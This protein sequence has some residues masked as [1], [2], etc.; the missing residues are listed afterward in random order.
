MDI[1]IVGAGLIGTRRAEDAMALGHRIL[2]VADTDRDRAQQLADLTKARPTV[3]WHEAVDDQATQVVFACSTN[4]VNAEVAIAALSRE[5]HV[6]IEQ[7]MGRNA[8]EASR[9]LS[10]ARE[11][12]VAL[13]AGLNYRYYPGVR[14]ARE[15]LDLGRIGRL[16]YARI[17]FGHGARPGYENDWKL[18]PENCGGG[19]LMDLGAHCIDLFRFFLGELWECNAM[20]RSDFWKK[21]IDDNVFLNFS[22]AD[23]RVGSAH[24]SLTQWMNTF[25]LE[26]GGTEGM[27]RV[28]GRSGF[29][30]PQHI[31]I[32]PRWSWMDTPDG[33][34]TIVEKTYP[35]EDVSFR[36]ELKEFFAQLAGNPA[37]I[38]GYDGFRTTE[39]IDRI[40][41]TGD[42][43]VAIRPE[44]K[45][46]IHH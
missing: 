36:E 3:F 2:W 10:A 9:I 45:E 26:L 21:G 17:H 20:L 12:G 34:L 46:V 39:I 8:A 35:M 14:D 44:G 18:D 7:P 32:I 5:K 40:Y 30:G 25:F 23:G 13:H 38:D 27:I 19:V 24:I 37:T 29:Y 41:Q 42:G 16:V 33:N 43:V 31:S 15:L 4:K 6:L 28:A 22:S 1:A 11:R